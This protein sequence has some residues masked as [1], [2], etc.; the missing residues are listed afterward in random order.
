MAFIMLFSVNFAFAQES[1]VPF[2]FSKENTAMQKLCSSV[3]ESGWLYFAP[4][5]DFTAKNFLN[6]NKA[7]L[8]F[9]IDDVMQ[10]GSE[11]KDEYGN[12]YWFH[13]YYKGLPVEGSAFMLM[14]KASKLHLIHARF[15]EKLNID[16]TTK[17]DENTALVNALAALEISGKD[18]K[19]T[20]P[21]SE[22]IKYKVINDLSPNNYFHCYRFAIENLKNKAQYTVYINAK[23]G[24]VVRKISEGI[25]EDTKSKGV[26]VPLSTNTLNSTEASSV[27]V[28]PCAASTDGMAYTLYNGY[29]NIT[30]SDRSIFGYYELFDHINGIEVWNGNVMPNINSCSN[31]WSTWRESTS[32][33]YAAQRSYAYFNQIHGR[34]RPREGSAFAPG[35]LF[36]NSLDIIQWTGGGRSGYNHFDHRISIFTNGGLL[37]NSVDMIGHHVTSAVMS[38]VN[39]TAITTY[40]ERPAYQGE[41][42]AIHESFA[43]IFGTCIEQFTGTETFDWTM[44]ENTGTPLRSLSTPS[45][46]GAPSSYNGTNWVNTSD[47]SEANDYGGVTTNSGVQNRWFYLLAQGGTQNGVTVS[48]I[49]ITNAAKIVYRNMT[50]YAQNQWDYNLARAGSINASNDIFGECSP[51]SNQVRNAWKAVGVGNNTDNCPK[52]TLSGSNEVV[53][54]GSSPFANVTRTYTVTTTPSTVTY[55]T[56]NAPY[57]WN[58]IKNGNNY[59]VN[60][61]GVAGS[62]VVYA[63][64]NT[65]GGNT[66]A[67][68]S[69]SITYV[70]PT[71]RTNTGQGVVDLDNEAGTKNTM[72]L[73]LSPNPSQGVLNI[74]IEGSSDDTNSTKFAKVFDLQGK[75]VYE[76]TFVGEN[77]LLPLENLINGMYIIQVSTPSQSKVSKFIINK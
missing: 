12:S 34:T 18:Y 61:N 77:T 5:A 19:I 42:G 3:D 58:V 32:S 75:K 56:D 2:A 76:S 4:E 47:V 30:T 49:G 41:A 16:L 53:T 8:G 70:C 67:N 45:F 52:I 60:T 39:N 11:Y 14:E 71:C 35:Q 50:V 21:S 65:P 48:G 59:T 15:V 24:E 36:Y 68:A 66:Q 74:N 46:Y 33:I 55:L 7:A 23:T 27:A 26:N 69:R 54:V 20:V 43:D 40:E 9:G 73:N 51:Q 37:R 6:Q 10:P 25:E 22:V 17:I 63:I 38:R 31:E 28:L 1:Y 64:M 13:H 44:G 72:K 62:L 57:A 29:R